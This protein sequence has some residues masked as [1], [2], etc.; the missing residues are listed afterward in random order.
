MTFYQN[1]PN[2]HNQYR[3]GKRHISQK[4]QEN[5]LHNMLP[6]TYS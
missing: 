4:M 1:L 3:T 2:L 6:C 5:V